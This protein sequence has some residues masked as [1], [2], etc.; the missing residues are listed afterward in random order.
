MLKKNLKTYKKSFNF[1]TIIISTIFALIILEWGLNFFSL[2]KIYKSEEAKIKKFV[3][4]RSDELAKCKSPEEWL[5]IK[6]M[7]KFLND[8]GFRNEAYGRNYPD[9]VEIVSDT[10]CLK[11]Y[12]DS[13]QM[14]RAIP[15][16]NNTYKINSLGYRGREWK[17]TKEDNE[18][19]VFLVGGSTAFSFFANE[20]NSIHSKLEFFLNIESD[21]NNNYKVYSAAATGIGAER[22]YRLLSREIIKYSPDIIIFLTGWNNA[23]D[24]KESI[25]YLDV[26]NKFK[27]TIIK[28]FTNLR[29]K[30]YFDHISSFA[31]N[32]FDK[33][34]KIKGLL[35]ED[36]FIPN[37]I[38]SME[39]CKKESLRCIFALQ[40]TLLIL[41][42]KNLSKAE[43]KIKDKYFKIDK[44]SR[45]STYASSY[46]KFKKFFLETDFEFLDLTDVGSDNNFDETFI[47]SVHLT[48]TTNKLI[49]EKIGK[50]ILEK[51]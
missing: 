14:R 12:Q 18:I 7:T 22:E 4:N 3:S 40:P 50:I 15:F 49:S 41:P 48:H 36:I 25:I 38:K 19:H 1:L 16:I 29:D 21:K 47:D 30:T 20:K 46:K 31:L 9:F 51:N 34:S 17:K 5:K 28:I 39:F 42:D 11:S 27:K 24:K 45:A 13:N 37:T 43:K 2:T 6:G 8:G 33:P 10:R 44:K 26:N 35:R 32:I 23:S